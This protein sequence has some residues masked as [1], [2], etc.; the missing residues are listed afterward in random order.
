MTTPGPY[1][2][3]EG[4]G[5]SGG[6]WRFCYELPDPDSPGPYKPWIAESDPISAISEEVPRGGGVAQ[7]SGLAFGLVD[8]DDQLTTL[9]RPESSIPLS[10]TAEPVA[11]GETEIDVGDG[12][13]FSTGQV[14]FCGSEAWEV[15]GVAT[16]TL[17]VE[18]GALG[19]RELAHES[20]APVLPHLPYLHNR[21]VVL[22]DADGNALGTYALDLV[23]WQA[24][25]GF[26]VWHFEARGQNAYLDKVVPQA[27]E[28]VEV[29]KRDIR[30]VDDSETEDL[31]AVRFANPLSL[32][33]SPANDRVYWQAEDELID[34]PAPSRLVSG[35]DLNPNLT[36]RQLFGTERSSLDLGSQ[37]T[38]VLADEDFVSGANSNIATL[39]KSLHFADI[40]LN[41]LTSPSIDDGDPEDFQNIISGTANFC[42]LPSGYGLGVPIG[43]IDL[44]SFSDVKARLPD[45]TF[46][47]FTLG[48]DP[49][50]AREVLSP[51]LEAAGCYLSSEGGRFRLV[52]PSRP[53]DDEAASLT[54][55]ADNVVVEGGEPVLSAS[56]GGDSVVRSVEFSN[57]KTEPFVVRSEFAAPRGYQDQ[58]KALKIEVTGASPATLRSLQQRGIARLYRET[59]PVFEIAADL[60]GA[61]DWLPGQLASLA[62]DEFPNLQGVRGVSELF[63]RLQSKQRLLGHLDA[64]VVRVTAEAYGGGISVARIAPAAVISSIASDEYTLATGGPAAGGFSVGHVVTAMSASGTRI[65]NAGHEEVEAVTGQVVRLAN[66]LTNVTAGDVLVLSDRPEQTAA[67]RA[68]YVFQVD[69]DAPDYL[70]TWAEP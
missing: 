69:L 34:A 16:D 52:L 18:R 4:V 27:I 3:I 12:S 54:I 38:R 26:G 46:D 2:T 21:R 48:P 14:V 15:T 24:A 28:Q 25:D 61:D 64:P 40:V 49:K 30:V 43:E 29:A 50:P 11:V 33:R 37:L 56:Y 62:L 31:L 17:T 60:F 65:S 13:Q 55:G 45:L 41:I 8:I 66:A 68:A 9:L 19:T 32:R 10:R 57:G 36:K 70:Y 42:T 51:M 1:L 58:G 47:W 23:S 44:D 59:R 67:N 6:L 7:A 20:G 39:S 35:I 63:L 53:F 5:D 22:R